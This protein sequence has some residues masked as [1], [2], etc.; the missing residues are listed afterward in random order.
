M[1]GQPFRCCTTTKI[2]TMKTTTKTTTTTTTAHLVLEYNEDADEDC[3]SEFVILCIKS[4]QLLEATAFHRLREALAVA[5]VPVP[6]DIT[7]DGDGDGDG[8]DGHTTTVTVTVDTTDVSYSTMCATFQQLL[9][10]VKALNVKD[11]PRRH[12]SQKRR[13]VLALVDR[14]GGYDRMSNRPNVALKYLVS[15]WGDV[16]DVDMDVAPRR[17]RRLRGARGARLACPSCPCAPSLFLVARR[18]VRLGRRARRERLGR[19]G[20]LA[21]VAV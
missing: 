18:S 11:E 14:E 17:P 19:L 3:T 2:M 10:L 13:P 21:P 1:L 12:Y 8:D 16:G 4:N 20:R 9:Q 7:F 5:G 15:V 6:V